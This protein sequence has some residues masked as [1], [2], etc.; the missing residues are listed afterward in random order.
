MQV[1]YMC[2]SLESITFNEGT[3]TLGSM[4]L[5][6]CPNVKEVTIPHSVTTIQD[7]ALGFLNWSEKVEGFT[8]R[9]Y[10]GTAAETYANAN[11]FA[12]V[13]ISE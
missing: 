8:I 6:G 3:E 4:L 9:G 11:S 10:A 12:F 7:M 13:A 1:F 5:T 2:T